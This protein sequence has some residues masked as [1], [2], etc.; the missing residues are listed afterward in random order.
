MG[1]CYCSHTC[2]DLLTLSPCG[3]T[4]VKPAL[5]GWKGQ[6]LSGGKGVPQKQ[7]AKGMGHLADLNQQGPQIPCG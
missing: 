4:S 3:Q 2:T 1:A 7:E 5:A 6:R